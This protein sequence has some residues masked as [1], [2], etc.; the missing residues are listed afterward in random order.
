MTK[1]QLD[2]ANAIVKRIEHLRKILDRFLLE[3]QGMDESLCRMT[4]FFIESNSNGFGFKE[5]I[6]QGELLFL[7]EAFNNEI[8]R[9]EAELAKI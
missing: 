5:N 8:I 4:G 7:I 6:N 3:A 1:Q 2:D 9:L